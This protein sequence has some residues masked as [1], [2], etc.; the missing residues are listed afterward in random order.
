MKGRYLQEFA[1]RL[2][3]LTLSNRVPQALVA[4]DYFAVAVS[5]DYQAVLPQA[6]RSVLLP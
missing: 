3:I 5:I 4:G 1:D 6:D 2:P